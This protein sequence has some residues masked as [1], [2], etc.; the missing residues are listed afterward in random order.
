MID[1]VPSLLSANFMHLCKDIK[2]CQKAGIKM[3]HYD[4]MDGHFVPNIS[5]GYSILADI[6]KEC[7][8][9]IDVHLMISNPLKYINCFIDAGASILTFHYEA[10]QNDEEIKQMIDYIHQKGI[11]AGI[12][13]NPQTPVD[14]IIP[15]LKDIDLVLVMS[16]EPG[17]G[18]QTFNFSAL[19]KIKELSKLKKKYH[20]II[21][22]DGGINDQTIK[23]ARAAGAD[24]FVAGSYIFKA[25]NRK[26]AI[27]S[28]L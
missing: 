15:Y 10:M 17:F 26:E 13:I 14:K 12:S 16:V 27:K 6:T 4:V 23:E 2:D 8:L 7:Q 28:L 24:L 1:I 19:E 18:G 21:E 20:F 25:E 22:V 9:D 5:F 3:F 11:Q